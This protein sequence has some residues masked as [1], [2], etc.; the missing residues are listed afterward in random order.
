V[1]CQCEWENDEK[2]SWGCLNDSVFAYLGVWGTEDD[3]VEDDMGVE[4]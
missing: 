2:T 3:T 1:P 4:C